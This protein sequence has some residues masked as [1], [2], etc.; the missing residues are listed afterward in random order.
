MTSVASEK[1]ENKNKRKG[2]RRLPRFELDDD[3]ELRCG[4]LLVGL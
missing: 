4:K 1:E 3:P 2:R